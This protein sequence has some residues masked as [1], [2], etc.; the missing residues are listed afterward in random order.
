[1]GWKDVPA[2]LAMQML[3][4]VVVDFAILTVWSHYGLDLQKLHP[5]SPRIDILTKL[6]SVVVVVTFFVQGLVAIG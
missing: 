5:E 1:M 2:S 6:V 4:E 3:Q